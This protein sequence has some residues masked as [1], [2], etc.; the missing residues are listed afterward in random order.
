MSSEWTTVGSASKSKSSRS[1]RVSK[2]SQVS[3]IPVS[4]VSQ[5]SPIPVSKVSASAA[6]SPS[7]QKLHCPWVLWY[8]D[9]KSRDWSLGGYKRLFR[10]DTVQ[11]FWISYNNLSDI[12]NS[13][14][15][16]MREGFPPLWDAPETIDGGAWTFKVD[17]RDLDKFW[18]DLSCLC[19]GETICEQSGNIIGLSISPKIRFVTV[20]VWTL[21]TEK[22]ITQFKDVENKFNFSSARF[23]PNRSAST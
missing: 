19:V 13:M 2:V 15:Y 23:T 12:P 14:Y 16:L 20:R 6:R 4:K 17:K 11:D 5:V 10:F 3:P 22:N 21:T 7:V 8:H 9:T 18:R 1:S